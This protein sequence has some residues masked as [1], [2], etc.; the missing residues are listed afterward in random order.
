MLLA[1]PAF[2]QDGALER[3]AGRFASG[4]DPASLAAARAD[5]GSLPEAL[6]ALRD[7]PELGYWAW[8]SWYWV[9]M[10]EAADDPEG[11]LVE[12]ER[13]GVPTS[14][15]RTLVERGDVLYAVLGD[16]YW[17]THWLEH[18]AFARAEAFLEACEPAFEAV[19][20][21]HAWALVMRADCARLQ[22]R[23]GA[24]L[25]LL[26]EA[27]RAL[28]GVPAEAEG[29]LELEARVMG[30]GVRT[31][32]EMM[33]GRL[34]QARRY[35]DL[36]GAAARRYAELYPP[37]SGQV[38]AGDFLR[39]ALVRAC[40][41]DLMAER[42]ETLIQRLDSV[43]DAE[44]LDLGTVREHYLGKAHANL[45]ELDPASLTLARA[46]LTRALEDDQ[47][48]LGAYVQ[49]FAQA[50]LARL[51][52]RAGDAEAFE[53]AL[54]AM[55]ALLAELPGDVLR[56]RALRATF[57]GRRAGSERGPAF[58]ALLDEVRAFADVRAAA[59]A[60]PGGLGDLKDAVRRDVL[61]SLLETG[62]AIGR[63]P[64]ALG[65]VLEVQAAGSA[66][67]AAG[68]L[69][70]QFTLERIQR[71]LIDRAGGADGGGVVLW[72]PGSHTTQLVVLDGTGLVSF[73]LPPGLVLRRA[74]E[75]LAREL[76]FS[77]SDQPARV[78]RAGEELRE[79]LFPAA[80]QQRMSAWSHV[81]F[82]GAEALGHPPL[83]VLPLGRGQ[84]G[85]ELA[86]GYLP[87]IPLGVLLAERAAAPGRDLAVLA[88]PPAVDADVS[89]LD[90]GAETW[91]AFAYPFGG[92]RLVLHDG[93]DATQAR[94]A[95]EDWSQAGALNVFCHGAY[96]GER[97]LPAGLVLPGESSFMGWEALSE[98]RVPP[99][100]VLSACGGARGPERLGEDGTSHLGGAFLAAGA[101]GVLVARGDLEVQS[102]LRFN[103]E[104]HRKLFEGASPLEALRHARGFVDPKLSAGLDKLVLLGVGHT[105]R[106]VPEESEEWRWVLPVG[107]LVVAGFVFALRRK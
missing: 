64:V 28:E 49:A 16:G 44:G 52:E 11:V 70:A 27:E 4:T 29:L 74:G 100:V 21:A 47:R 24:A 86:M 51:A 36:E 69:E 107:L 94:L 42:Y 34:V 80:V 7:A 88:G 56:P 96:D 26:E 32:L 106:F 82:V 10:A 22:E 13:L 58:E 99:L 6:D 38:R 37:S 98:L 12:L 9:A 59:P 105:P 71:A 35:S 55:D 85:T 91:R 19:P 76:H 61:A 23:W 97:L 92:E 103:R 66:A 60:L 25:E 41:L 67:R 53:G 31:Q 79:L 3:W 84:F 18:G 68:A 30:F 81:Y 1:S 8:A 77:G 78:A 62:A 89:G 102:T 90:F 20:G 46:H 83:E 95:G 72:V 75:R 33:L 54:A 73:S 48:G 14:L 50:S 65:A 43:D 101:S 45:A 93:V 104:L 40:D 57:E 2:A 5:L 63:L 39:M 87:S 15:R 17:V